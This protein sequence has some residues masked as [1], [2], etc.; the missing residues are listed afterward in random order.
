MFDAI[1]HILNFVLKLSYCGE[2]SFGA[3]SFEMMVRP[4]WQLQITF[5][6]CIILALSKTTTTL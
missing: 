5:I 1:F 3:L 2:T 6:I 4:V